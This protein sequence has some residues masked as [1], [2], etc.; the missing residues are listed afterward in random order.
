MTALAHA[1]NDELQNE[2]LGRSVQVTIHAL[3]PAYGDASLIRQV[4][5][6]LLSNSLKFS[7]HGPSAQIEVRGEEGS[8]VNVYYV[9]DNG[10][11]FDMRYYDQLF[12]IFHRLHRDDEFPGTGV[13]LAI[14]QRVIL[15][16]NGRVWAEGKPDEGAT[17]FFELP[18]GPTNE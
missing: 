9:K 4:W 1:A 14:V 11:G 6:N 18:Q 13:G 12:G 5:V 7:A 17:F 8:G 2:R 15:R 10:A 3:P 16:H